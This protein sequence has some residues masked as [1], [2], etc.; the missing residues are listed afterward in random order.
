MPPRKSRKASFSD[1]PLANPST[2]IHALAVQF[3]DFLHF[4]DPSPLYVV[5][6]SMAANMMSGRPVWLMLIGPS[7]CQPKGS[8]V[9]L[10][11]GKWTTVENIKIGDRVMSPQHDGSVKP[12]TVIRTVR[13]YSVPLYRVGLL[14]HKSIVKS[15]TCSGDHII[16][17]TGC[18]KKYILGS[19]AKASK[20][21]QRSS[22]DEMSAE[23]FSSRGSYF[24]G[25]S[26]SFTSPAVSLREIKHKVNPYVVGALLGDGSLSGPCPVFHNASQE[27]FDRLR[28]HG[29]DFGI[30]YMKQD[31]PRAKNGFQSR[32]ILQPAAEDIRT[33]ACYGAKSGRKFI[34]VE[35]KRGSIF[36]RL[37]L[38]AGMIDTDGSKTS[39]SSKSER[40]ARDFMDT[41][42]SVGG[43]AT[44]HS[45]MT[46]CDGKRFKS[47]RVHYKFAEYCPNLTLGHKRNEHR[48]ASSTEYP[49]DKLN[50]RTRK[51]VVDRCG[52]GDVYGFTLDS[53]SGWYITDDWMVTH[54]C[55]KSQLL[56]TLSKVSKVRVTSK[57]KGEAAL[58]SG[59]KRKEFKEG[60]KGG[61]LREI[62]DRGA[63]VCKDFT[64][65]LSMQKDALVELLS[66]FRELY[67]GNWSREIGAEGGRSLTWPAQGK[68]GKLAMLTGVT[69][70]IDRSHA[71]VTE[72][73]ERFLFYRYP[74]DGGDDKTMAALNRRDPGNRMELDM[75]E[76]VKDFFEGLD[77]SWNLT[78]VPRKL[79]HSELV[80][81]T[82][83]GNLA[84]MCRG[85]VARDSYSKEICDVPSAEEPMRIAD[86]LAQLYLGMEYI[87]VGSGIGGEAWQIIRKMALDCMPM[88]RS[89]ALRTIMGSKTGRASPAMIADAGCFS[90]GTADRALEELKALRVVE[91]A[92]TKISGQ[93]GFGWQLGDRAVDLIKRGWK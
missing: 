80:G 89:I 84:A 2:P 39:Y 81:M 75:R 93:G 59:T 77:L 42:H 19:G 48:R 56:M 25:C 13:Q 9:L 1:S 5:M 23:Q 86:E 29:L 10:A 36:Q 67:D 18:R 92:R 73:G 46:R 83:I 44:I 76:T 85:F 32:S 8:K 6:G 72:M 49:G 79:K 15:Y 27:I 3:Q 90:D 20:K 31:D 82:S 30:N 57:I 4:P 55:G 33:L 38:L 53:A 17:I 41:V 69:P 43:F 65:I 71:M 66:A 68:I 24:R 47:F 62:G 40:L 61:L 14:S 7:S 52:T 28:S 16:P 91:R 63:I 26:K 58:L 37:E 78:E 45:R 12:V 88:T 74:Y 54:N 35:Y 34:P 87:G 70:A 22:L 50:P 11:N 51:V 64:T 60:A 21:A